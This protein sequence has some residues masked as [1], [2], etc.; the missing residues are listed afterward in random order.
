[1]QDDKIKALREKMYSWLQQRLSY[2][3]WQAS[4]TW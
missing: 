3:A 4:P 2:W 1:M